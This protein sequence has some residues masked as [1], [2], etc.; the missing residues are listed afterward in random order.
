MLLEY[1]NTLNTAAEEV[2]FMS[3]DFVFLAVGIMQVVKEL[4]I[5]TTKCINKQNWIYIQFHCHY[6]IQGLAYWILWG[7]Q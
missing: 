4:E 1:L 2:F 7:E 5:T 6:H 3:Q